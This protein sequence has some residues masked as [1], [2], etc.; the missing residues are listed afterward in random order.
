MFVRSLRGEPPR[1]AADRL[2]LASA[3]LAIAFFASWIAAP[4]AAQPRGMFPM[5]DV[6]AATAIGGSLLMI[7]LARVLQDRVRLLGDLYL[8][9]I[10]L[11]CFTIALSEQ[12]LPWPKDHV[13]RGVSWVCLVLFALMLLIPWSP[14]KALFASFLGAST[15]PLALFI[16]VQKGNPVPELSVMAGLFLPSYLAVGLSWLFARIA[17]DV[18]PD[19]ALRVFGPYELEALLGK[20]GMGEVWRARHRLL[21][22]RAAIKLVRPDAVHLAG[23]E[24]PRKILRRFEREAKATSMLASPHTISIYDFGILDDG[25]FYYAME[26]LDGLDLET[27]IERFG[28]MPP[29]RVV[30]VLEQVC[31][32]LEEAHARAMIHRDIKPA[33]V[34][35]CRMGLLADVVK[36]LDFGLVVSDPASS[37]PF[38]RLTS[39]GLTS[40]TPSYMA[41]EIAEGGREIDGRADL[42]ALGCVAYWLL[43]GTPVFD[44]S[45]PMKILLAHVQSS[46]VPPS[47][48]SP[49][50]IPSDVEELVL[51]LLKKSPDDRPQNA[52]E[53]RRRL[54]SCSLAKQWTEERA[55]EWWNT[56]SRME[57]IQ[58]NATSQAEQ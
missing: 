23:G 32:S 8:G 25:T 2:G 34:Y 42:Y 33:N 37:Q 28:P 22:R 56:I 51:S 55:L 29:E 45:S 20:G 24:E 46:P 27:L 48:R 44:G 6:A 47:E 52:R 3:I 10:V 5:L 41:P 35:V 1:E 31:R 50:P 4:P 18:G 58:T 21:A 16:A 15:G 57:S 43:T 53:L 38:T 11:Y 12:W 39:E 7:L 54:E 40:G 14:K 17:R 36:V 26:L 30:H 49:K 13:V 19:G 9:Y